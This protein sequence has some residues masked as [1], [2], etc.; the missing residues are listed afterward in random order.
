[1]KTVQKST[2]MAS[3][4]IDGIDESNVLAYF[5]RLNQSDFEGVAALFE[6]QGY[7]QPPF[8]QMIQGKEKIARYL[9][10]ETKGMRFCPESGEELGDYGSGTHFEVQGRVETGLFTVAVKWIMQLNLAK[11]ITAVEVKLLDPLGELLNLKQ[12]F[13]S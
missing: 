7:L 5:T 4:I 2:V 12:R 1:M 11:E 3:I 6:Q 13:Q 8:D 9:E 10:K